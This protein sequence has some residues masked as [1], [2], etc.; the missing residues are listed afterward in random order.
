MMKKIIENWSDQQ[1]ELLKNEWSYNPNVYDLFPNKSK[2][3]IQHKASNLGIKRIY[4][5]PQPKYGDL[6]CLL[7][8]TPISYYW[9]GFLLA[10]GHFGEKH[11]K[12]S[13]SYKDL[14]HLYKYKNFINYTQEIKIYK[15]IPEIKVID[16]IIV[17]KIREKYNICNTKTYHP[18]DI[19]KICGDFLACFI[20]GFIDGDGSIQKRVKTLK[21]PNNDNTTI[22]IKVHSSW[23]SNIDYMNKYI[24]EQTNT[25]Y[26][27]SIIDSKGYCRKIFSNNIQ[28]Q[29]LKRMIIQYNLP[30][31]DRKWNLIDEY[32]IGK[33]QQSLINEQNVL[34]LLNEGYENLTEIGEILGYHNSVIYQIIK[35]LN[36][37][38]G[39]HN[40]PKRRGY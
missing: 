36:I 7:E 35:R 16:S 13:L 10:D 38:I 30:V 2:S 17:P 14:D 20:T 11:I 4:R 5:L 27:E 21:R 29:F 8:E 25:K 32:K 26:I 22:T 31:L 3:N 12:L 1:I 34:R 24:T 40:N 18:C 37:N 6:S 15:N 23:K 39:K 19:S 28:Q 33:N 9:L